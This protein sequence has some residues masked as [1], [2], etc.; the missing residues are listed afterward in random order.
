MKKAMVVLLALALCFSFVGVLAAQTP[1]IGVNIYKFD[2]TFMSYV[3]NQIEAAAREMVGEA[4]TLPVI[5]DPVPSM[6]TPAP[7][8][9]AK[10]LKLLPRIGSAEALGAVAT[11]KRTHAAAQRRIVLI[12]LMILTPMTLTAWSFINA[13]S[14]F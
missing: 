5:T 3:R 1:K 9:I 14:E 12:L 6:V 10:V 2:D 7:P 11:W 8:R 13:S 4:P